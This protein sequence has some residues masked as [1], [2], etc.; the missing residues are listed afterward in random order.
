MLGRLE[1]IR[2]LNDVFRVQL[3]NRR[4]YRFWESPFHFYN[5]SPASFAFRDL[6]KNHDQAVKT[7]SIVEKILKFDPSLFPGRKAEERPLSLSPT[8]RNYGN[9]FVKA[10]YMNKLASDLTNRF[11]PKPAGKES[12]KRWAIVM[13]RGITPV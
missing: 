12:A 6:V 11:G 3:V 10:L 8:M 2:A 13:R 5:S 7:R 1:E 9:A 4:M